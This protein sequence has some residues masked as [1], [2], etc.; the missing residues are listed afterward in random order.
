MWGELVEWARRF[1]LRPDMTIPHCVD[2][3]ADAIAL[4]R[5][6]HAA[7]TTAQ[8]ARGVPAARAARSGLRG[9]VQ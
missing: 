4:I 6:R 1:M 3:A 7:W 8:S 2:G 5:T 9:V